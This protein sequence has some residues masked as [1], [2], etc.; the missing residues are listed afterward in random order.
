[1]TS[2]IDLITEQFKGCSISI[3]PIDNYWN[4]TQMAQSVGKRIDKFLKSEGTKDYASALA[5]RLNSQVVE[6]YGQNGV[7]ELKLYIPRVSS[8]TPNGVIEMVERKSLKPLIEVYKGGVPE[9]QG[10]WG[11]QRLALKF[12]A[13]LK[14]DLE[15]WVFEV[16]E[17]LFTEGQVR[18]IDELSI[19]NAM[20]EHQYN[21]A[22]YRMDS[23]GLL[24]S[25]VDDDAPYLYDW[26]A[27]VNGEEE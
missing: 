10:T 13:W 22:L 12:A 16:I 8:D 21:Q 14:P 5:Y 24:Q 17:K 1:M 7:S 19:Q 23:A 3:R 25:M 26:E 20:L 6:E 18:L 9:L 15:V 4:L 27:D 2:S 11:H